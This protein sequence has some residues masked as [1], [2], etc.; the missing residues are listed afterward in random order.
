MKALYIRISNIYPITD[1]KRVNEKD[2]DLIIEDNVFG[3]VKFFERKGGKDIF[4]LI[5]TGV[6]KSLS[7]YSIENLGCNLSDV[8]NTINFLSR[9]KVSLEIINQGLITLSPDG[10]ENPI[11]KMLISILE[12]ILLMDIHHAKEHQMD[13]IM[14]RKAKGLYTGRKK[15]T[16]E[17]V[18]KFLSKEK[19]KKAL[20]LLKNGYKSVEVAKILKLHQNT[21]LKIKKIGFS[22]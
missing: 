12:S 7:V 19:N 21:I 11:S 22:R 15:G 18:H 3:T 9:N 6:I 16:K 8:M 17:D 10:Q 14:K 4:R 20:E 2:F 1:R 5:T 13:G